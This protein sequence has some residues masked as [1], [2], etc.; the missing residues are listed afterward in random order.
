MP[1]DSVYQ[2][3]NAMSQQIDWAP[4]TILEAFKTIPDTKLSR[5]W[6]LT[7][8]I[9]RGHVDQT[10]DSV[11]V[12]DLT[13]AFDRAELKRDYPQVTLT[14]FKPGTLLSH[15]FAIAPNH[16][17][18]AL[19]HEDSKHKKDYLIWKNNLDTKKAL[20]RVK[21]AVAQNGHFF[22][23]KSTNTSRDNVIAHQAGVAPAKPNFRNYARESYRHKRVEWLTFL[24][25]DLAATL[26]IAERF[27]KEQI[28][29]IFR[30][31]LTQLQGIHDGSCLGYAGVFRDV[32]FRNFVISMNHEVFLV[33]LDS[34]VPLTPGEA[35]VWGEALCTNKYAAPEIFDTTTKT[36]RTQQK[37]PF[38]FDNATQQW[39][40]SSRQSDCIYLTTAIDIYALGKSMQEVLALAHIT[41]LFS[42]I[43]HQKLRIF[44]DLMIDTN[45]QKRLDALALLKLQQDFF[46]TRHD[47]IS[48]VTLEAN[49]V[50]QSLVQPLCQLDFNEALPDL[51]SRI[52]GCKAAAE[53]QW[54]QRYQPAIRMTQGVLSSPTSTVPT[55]IIESPFVNA[56]VVE[57][58]RKSPPSPAFNALGGVASPLRN[59]A[60][61]MD[62]LDAVGDENRLARHK[63]KRAKYN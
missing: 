55:E 20:E 59:A 63:F 27:T 41:P 21:L 29:T 25:E 46:P 17:V 35:G 2:T 13:R 12:Y 24:G 31:C 1:K 34:I 28:L 39:R 40:P 36:Y 8:P 57:L 45:P 33:D 23:Y 4:T 50:A 56:N 32:K 22:I 5:S 60:D 19:Q 43:E 9:A 11:N 48:F 26:A 53:K 30:Q 42:D 10:K 49:V 7:I 14:D 16:D 52:H 18:Y 58:K 61:L 54:Q 15:A 38:V 37:K 47:V 6:C 51:A 3:V 62:D 44:I